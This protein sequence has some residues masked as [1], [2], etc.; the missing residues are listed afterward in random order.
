MSKITVQ[1]RNLSICT[2]KSLTS[3]DSL[4]PF[5]SIHPLPFQSSPVKKKTKHSLRD[6]RVCAINEELG[7]KRRKE[8]TITMIHHPNR[9]ACGIKGY[10]EFNNFKDTCLLGCSTVKTGDTDGLFRGS[11]YL[12]RRPLHR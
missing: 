5:S 9:K 4:S 12:H 2:L 11:Y 7:M 3:F 6:Q 8:R 10:T 1:L